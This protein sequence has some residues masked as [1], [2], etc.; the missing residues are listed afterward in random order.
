MKMIHIDKIN[1][2]CFEFYNSAEIQDNEC[3]FHAGVDFAINEYKSIIDEI[4]NDCATSAKAYIIDEF[5]E[6]KED[7]KLIDINS[8]LKLKEKYLKS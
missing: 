5:G 1:N 2:A 6:K 7:S 3:A 4:I 8:I